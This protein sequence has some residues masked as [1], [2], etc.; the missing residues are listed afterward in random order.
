MKCFLIALCFSSMTLLGMSIEKMQVDQCSEQSLL[1]QIQE[2]QQHVDAAHIERAKEILQLI[3]QM[4]DGTTINRLWLQQQFCAVFGFFY[5]IDSS[6]SRV[7]LSL[8]KTVQDKVWM[9]KT[10]YVLGSALFARAQEE[11]AKAQEP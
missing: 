8:V 6:I 1:A 4:V 5:P 7:A 9:Q 3:V 11:F 10:C 2:I